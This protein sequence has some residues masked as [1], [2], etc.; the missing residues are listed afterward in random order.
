MIKSNRHPI[1]CSSFNSI[2]GSRGVNAGV[3][4]IKYMPI[5][6]DEVMD[7]VDTRVQATQ[8]DNAYNEKHRKNVEE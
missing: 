6:I 3:D 4:M 2:L 1:F 7:L 8:K 5:S